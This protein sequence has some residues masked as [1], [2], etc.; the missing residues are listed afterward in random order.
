MVVDSARGSV[1]V[2]VKCAEKFVEQGGVV[3]IRLPRGP[4]NQ[5]HP[6]LARQ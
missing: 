6:L 4:V 5:H 2:R 3:K 1:L